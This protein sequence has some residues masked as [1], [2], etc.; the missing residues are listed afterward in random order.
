M[1]DDTCLELLCRSALPEWSVRCGD[2]Q[3]KQYI[4]GSSENVGYMWSMRDFWKLTAGYTDP[5]KV[6]RAVGGVGGGQKSFYNLYPPLPPPA[7]LQEVSGPL[8]RIEPSPVGRGWSSM[9]HCQGVSSIWVNGGQRAVWQ[10][11]PP[12]SLSAQAHQGWYMMGRTC[13]PLSS[14]PQLIINFYD[15]LALWSGALAACFWAS[16]FSSL[17]ENW[18]LLQE[19]VWA[20][21]DLVCQ[22]P[23]RASGSRI[24]KNRKGLAIS[25]EPAGVPCM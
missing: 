19:R 10:C 14:G 25:S 3:I 20:G 1:V 17:K 15:L 18:Y 4:S 24:R 22:V 6:P 5:A 8:N 13:V 23:E 9:N 16:N 7:P 2:V 12:C 21:R 11:S